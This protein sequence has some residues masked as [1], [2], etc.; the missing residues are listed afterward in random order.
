[1]MASASSNGQGTNRSLRCCPAC[2]GKVSLMGDIVLSRDEVVETEGLGEGDRDMDVLEEDVEVF[3]GYIERIEWVFSYESFIKGRSKEW[4]EGSVGRS[5]VL[6]CLK[7]EDMASLKR[8][9]KIESLKL[10]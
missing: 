6:E 7:E 4:I 1:M 5:D 8:S 9:T 3:L 10:V 2:I